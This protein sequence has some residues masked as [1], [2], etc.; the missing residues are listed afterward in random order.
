[1]AEFPFLHS[2]L[3]YSNIEGAVLFFLGFVLIIMI[4]VGNF[5]VILAVIRDN[6]LKSHQNC[7]IGT[8]GVNK[9]ILQQH[10]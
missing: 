10:S 8:R 3:P 4:I 9:K 6:T 1:M 7:F 2:D 5:L